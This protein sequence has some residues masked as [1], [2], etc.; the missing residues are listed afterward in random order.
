MCIPFSTDNDYVFVINMFP[1]FN[2]QCIY[3][4]ISVLND[5]MPL[6][7]LEQN[8]Y[9]VIFIQ[10]SRGFV[11]VTL[12]NYWID[13][14]ETLKNLYVKKCNFASLI[15][16]SLSFY[17]NI[18]LVKSSNEDKQCV[19]SI[20]LWCYS[21]LKLQANKMTPSNLWNS[22]KQKWWI[23]FY[24]KKYCSSIIWFFKSI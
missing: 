17:P 11:F 16:L 9:F 22:F 21:T 19:P 5:I 8:R 10:Q 6:C 15:I 13:F 20:R 12:H 3:R 2:F 24:L 23:K 14:I 4:K 7:F 18:D 1:C